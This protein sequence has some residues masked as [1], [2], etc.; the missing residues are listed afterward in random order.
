M[1]YKT[2]VCLQP[3]ID[4][5][6]MFSMVLI[7]NLLYSTAAKIHVSTNNIP[8]LSLFWIL[9]LILATFVLYQFMCGCR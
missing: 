4:I 9:I 5:V 7:I 8:S 1:G 6:S 3:T 2:R